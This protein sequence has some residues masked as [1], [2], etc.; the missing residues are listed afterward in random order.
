MS[1]HTLEPVGPSAPAPRVRTRRRAI[2]SPLSLLASGEPML[3]LTGG[4]LVI[5]LVMILGLLGLVIYFGIGTFWPAAVVRLERVDGKVYMGEVTRSEDFELGRQVVATMS[6]PL[7]EE[8]RKVLGDEE[9]VEA[10]RR[11]LRT[12]NFELSQTHFHWVADYEI[13]PEG[14]SRPEWA[15]TVERLS[16]GRFYGTPQAFT[17]REVPQAELNETE[18]RR[19]FD[20]LQAVVYRVPREQRAELQAMLEE[21]AEPLAAARTAFDAERSKH[22][23]QLVAGA[24]AVEGAEVEIVTET[25]GVVPRFEWKPE[26]GLK[27]VRTTWKGPEPVWKKFGELHPV[28]RSRAARRE[29]VEKHELGRLN[30]EKE[31]ARLRVRSAE[32]R[33]D[34]PVL[35]GPVAKIVLARNEVRAIEHES[36][37]YALLPEIAAAHFGAESPLT[38]AVEKLSAALVAN[39]E[40]KLAEPRARLAEAEQ[41]L[42][43]APEDIRGAV[44]RLFEVEE[45]NV[46]E[47]AQIKTEVDEL[48]AENARYLLHMMTGD[49]TKTDLELGEIVR[50]YPANRLNATGKLGVYF[51][52]WW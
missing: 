35:D 48:E 11:L 31:A 15:L 14:E 12:G 32:L 27:E 6:G 29:Y 26:Q 40:T 33:N 43:E 21:V 30:E 1:T 23:Q 19:Q 10:H 41:T 2:S 42:A 51:S 9:E 17:V 50:A 22:E 36:Q 8:A 13:K 34:Y 5:C 20:F 28:I 18:K 24:E 46:Q 4:S 3:W 7:A 16:Y 25:A 45:L 38:A 44:A 39:L 52:R 37:D 49:G 47:Q